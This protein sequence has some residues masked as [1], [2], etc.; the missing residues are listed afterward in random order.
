MSIK[1]ASTVQDTSTATG[2]LHKQMLDLGLTPLESISDEQPTAPQPEVTLPTP[3]TLPDEVVSTAVQEGIGDALSM[4]QEQAD[5]EARPDL[6]ERV[7]T[8]QPEAWHPRSIEQFLPNGGMYERASRLRNSFTPPR[9]LNEMTGEL[10]P[11]V[12]TDTQFNFG[13]QDPRVIGETAKEGVEPRVV[14]RALAELNLADEVTGDIAPSAIEYGSL[15]VENAL[16]EQSYVKNEDIFSPEYDQKVEIP[17][18]EG[19]QFTTTNTDLLVGNTLLKDLTRLSGGSPTSNP[20]KNKA[21]AVGAAFMKAWQ[22]ANP[23]M[24]VSF[25]D[26]NSGQIVYQMTQKGANLINRGSTE[27]KRILS[28]AIIRS[29]KSPLGGMVGENMPEVKQR[30]GAIAPREDENII[31]AAKRNLSTIPNVV[32]KQRLSI[33]LSTL[34]PILQKD[35]YSMVEGD[36]VLE[37]LAGMNNIGPDQVVKFRSKQTLLKRKQESGQGLTDA[38]AAYDPNKI[39]EDLRMKIAQE[40]YHAVLEKDGANFLTYYTQSF[41]GRIAPQQTVFDPTSSKLIRFL[42]RNVTPVLIKP[43]SRQDRNIR[44]MYAMMLVDGADTLL[45][46]AREAALKA[47]AKQLYTWGERLREV[48]SATMTDAQYNAITEALANKMSLTDPNFPKFNSLQLDPVKDAS[49]IEAIRE[50]GEDGHHFIDGLMDFQQYWYNV[51]VKNRPYHSHFNAYIDGK[52]NGL[53]SNGIMMGDETVAKATGVF[54]NSVEKLLDDGDIRDQLLS[55]LKYNLDNHGIMEGADAIFTDPDQMAAAMQ[56]FEDTISTRELNK[57]VTMTFG[58]GRDV[59][60]FSIDVKAT[61]F[62][63]YQGYIDKAT[64][65]IAQGVDKDGAVDKLAVIETVMRNDKL[66]GSLVDGLAK[67][68][69][70]GIYDTFTGNGIEAKRLMKAAAAMAAFNNKLFTIRGPV[71]SLVKNVM[72]DGSVSYDNRGMTLHF[73]GVMSEG[74]DTAT[75]TRFSVNTAEGP[76]GGQYMD[77]NTVPTALAPKTMINSKGQEVQVFGAKAINGAVVGPVQAVDAATVALTVTGESWKRLKASSGGKPYIHTIYDAFKMDANGYDV[78]LEETNKNWL[79]TAMKYNYIMEAYNATG[80][81]LTDITNKIKALKEKK[82][83]SVAFDKDFA[84]VRYLVKKS[85]VTL[86]NG[87]E[88]WTSRPLAKFLKDTASVPYKVGGQEKLR[89]PT[90]EESYDMA[91]KIIN[92]SVKYLKNDDVV[93]SVSDLERFFVELKD[94]LHLKDRMATLASKIEDGKRKLLKQIDPNLKA[95]FESNNFDIAEALAK[96]DFKAVLQYYSH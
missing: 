55:T 94:V 33:A 46:K 64:A 35:S 87:R 18:K 1:V 81:H 85:K 44:Q 86:P 48:M 56:L 51:V 90:T 7:Q 61:L 5:R 95:L 73:G 80:K 31:E 42:T 45:P 25:K 71:G 32:D 77:Y 13:L 12:L 69:T 34:L 83:K 68:Y 29:L 57:Y 38:E 72:D 84:F 62:D 58:Y 6:Y 70:R 9:K 11:Q 8:A 96:G 53:A 39:Y 50:K 27:R 26:P 88:M 79:H 78:I 67:A 47:N 3:E 91:A 82:I 59:E 15:I 63:V 28:K 24:M 92:N 41:N 21:G 65:A 36:P 10:E 43:K 19:S 74:Y 14:L 54:R 2:S 20:D 75:K 66:V 17:L 22:L 4:V 16:Q 30:S 37:L 23:D 52:T 93:I 76:Q 40:L 89:A 60:S 49:L